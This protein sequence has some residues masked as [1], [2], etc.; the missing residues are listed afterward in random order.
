MPLLPKVTVG[1]AAITVLNGGERKAYT[2]TNVGSGT[3][4]LSLSGD[5][6]V[7]VLGGAKP[8]SPFAPMTTITCSTEDRRSIVPNQPVTAIA[9]VSTVIAI[10]VIP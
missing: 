2:L 10:E 1:T 8:G 4:Y 9:D 6:G 5:L 7:T 3:A